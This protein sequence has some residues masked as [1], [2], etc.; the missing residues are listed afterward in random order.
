MTTSKRKT[1]RKSTKKQS[2]EKSEVKEP[3]KKKK[4]TNLHTIL[5][6]K[7]ILCHTCKNASKCDDALKKTYPY[8][9]MIYVA[10]EN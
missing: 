4:T 10:K 7:K 1:L 6:R 2:I 9:C 8:I 5:R 3:K